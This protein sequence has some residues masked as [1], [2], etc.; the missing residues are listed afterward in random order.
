[1]PVRIS[2]TR[3]VP[4]WCLYMRNDDLD[5]LK[6]MLAAAKRIT[7]KIDGLTFDQFKTMR[8]F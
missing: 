7:K 3:S 6:T 5:T 2:S 1:M 4:N 8:T